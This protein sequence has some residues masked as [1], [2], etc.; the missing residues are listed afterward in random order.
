VLQE[1]H[2]FNEGWTEMAV[3]GANL[4]GEFERRFYQFADIA[5]RLAH[6]EPAE[7]AAAL[8]EVYGRHIGYVLSLLAG[9]A[10]DGDFAGWTDEKPSQ[11]LEQQ[12]LNRAKQHLAERQAKQVYR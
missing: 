12:I 9:M 10:Q 2:T 5:I 6:A 4:G 8:Q 1:Y 7:R 3:G 11:N